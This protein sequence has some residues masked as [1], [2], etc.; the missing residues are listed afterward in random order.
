MC[1]LV[2]LLTPVPRGEQ[3]LSA[4][5]SPQCPD[6][7]GKAPSRLGR[8]QRPGEVPDLAA[9]PSFNSALATAPPEPLTWVGHQIYKENVDKLENH[10][11]NEQEQEVWKTWPLRK[12]RRQ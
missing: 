12:S 11:G 1:H 2:A 7:L 3:V 10:E 8:A 6:F 5:W 9:T 4:Q